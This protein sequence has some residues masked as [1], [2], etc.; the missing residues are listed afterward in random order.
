[1]ERDRPDDVD[2]EVEDGEHRAVLQ[3]VATA[4]RVEDEA[5]E[6]PDHSGQQER[7]GHHEER[8]EDRIAQAR[9][10]RRE[11]SLAHQTATSS[12]SVISRSDAIVA[13]TS[14]S[15][16]SSSTVNR[17]NSVSFDSLTPP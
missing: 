10:E 17:P 8:L 2:D 13:A 3:Q 1:M 15:P 11:I 7:D 5:Q 12:M 6:Y 14:C 4:G 16:P 9:Q